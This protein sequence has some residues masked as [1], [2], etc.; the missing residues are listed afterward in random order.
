MKVIKL[1]AWEEPYEAFITKVREQELKVLKDSSYLGA[2]SMFSWSCA[3]FFVSLIT[4][5]IYTKTG[6]TLTP[7]KAFVSLSLFNILRFPM[8]MLPMMIS[9]LVEAQVSVNRLKNFLLMPELKV[10]GITRLAQPDASNDAISIKNGTF[11]WSAEPDK[12]AC[13]KVVNSF[14]TSFLICFFVSFLCM[15]SF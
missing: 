4:F 1:Y 6:N 9:S 15:C 7:E 2:I 13:L 8:T 11:A 5:M 10:D 3:P 12:E 14:I